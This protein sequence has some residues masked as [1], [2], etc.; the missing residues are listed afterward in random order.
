MQL[1][2]MFGI[3]R[4]AKATVQSL[5]MWLIGL[6]SAVIVSLI[7]ASDAIA[8][9]HGGSSYDNFDAPIK[10][11]WA[12]KFDGLFDYWNGNFRGLIIAMSAVLLP[13]CLLLII[14][15]GRSKDKSTGWMRWGALIAGVT[16]LAIWL[17]TVFETVI[18]TPQEARAK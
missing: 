7:Q 8:S 2:S 16:L 10:T 18:V 6:S 11:D 4:T 5:H 9:S 13:L 14:V 12:Q 1:V 17:P 3:I 15:A